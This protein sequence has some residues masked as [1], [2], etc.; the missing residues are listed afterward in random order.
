MKLIRLELKIR[1]SIFPTKFYANF[2]FE[3]NRNKFRFVFSEERQ[4]PSYQS[5]GAPD[6]P[7]RGNHHD[8]RH[9]GG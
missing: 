6:N 3:R 7:Y 2:S 4:K 9:R 8:W 1:K 5:K